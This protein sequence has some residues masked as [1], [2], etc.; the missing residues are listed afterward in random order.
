MIFLQ[1]TAGFSGKGAGFHLKGKEIPMG[2]EE[3]VSE[4]HM[5]SSPPNMH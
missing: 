4:P 5:V 2:A 3:A 1:H